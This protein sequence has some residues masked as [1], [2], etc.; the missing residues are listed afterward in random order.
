MK[1]YENIARLVS[2]RLSCIERGN[3]EWIGKHEDAIL[4]IVENELPYGS[5]FDNGTTIDFSKSTGEKLVFLTSYHFMD[6]M[7]GY[8]GWEDYDIV[9]TPSLCFSYNIKVVGKN[10]DN[11]KDY[12]ADMFWETLWRDVKEPIPQPLTTG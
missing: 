3:E 2:A 6:E 8:D 12:I 1:T 5:G 9:V 10:R 4:E 7:G 11:I